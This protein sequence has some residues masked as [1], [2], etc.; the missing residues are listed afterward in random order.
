MLKVTPPVTSATTPPPPAAPSE[1]DYEDDKTPH[2][3]ALTLEPGKPPCTLVF[4]GALFKNKPE[5]F[6]ITSVS[7][8]AT[9]ESGGCAANEFYNVKHEKKLRPDDMDPEPLTAGIFLKPGQTRPADLEGDPVWNVTEDLNF[10]GVM[11]LC[12]VSMTGAYNYSQ[13]CW[14][15]DTNTRKFVR[16]TELDE[17]IF[18]KI[19]PKTKKLTSAY[20]AG[21]PVYVNHE[22]EWRN[23][24]LVKTYH[25]TSY[26]GEKPDGTPLAAGFS[27]WVIRHELRNGKFVKTFD[28]PMRETP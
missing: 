21:G 15:F 1:D 8:I 9:E 27:H 18:M 22:Y 16:N 14:L 5:W 11:D 7:R 23:N 12:V 10:D 2:K 19:D 6:V 24:K 3:V 26:F 20:R 25:S 4:D 13:Y 17:L 28:G